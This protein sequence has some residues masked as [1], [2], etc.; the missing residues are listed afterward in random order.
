MWNSGAAMWVRQPWRSGIR[1]SSD[2]AASM[3]ASL[4]GAPLGV[5]VVPEVRITIR[6]CRLGRLQVVVRVPGDQRLEGV[7]ADVAV[8][9]GDDPVLDVRVGEQLGELLVVDHGGRPLALEDV[10]E[11]GAGERGVEVEQVGAELGDGDAGVDEAAVVA[12]H[13]GDAVALV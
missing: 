6:A 11:L 10:D 12:A 7:L 3:P 1:E 13:H 9:P 2:T 4:R 8:G 5:P